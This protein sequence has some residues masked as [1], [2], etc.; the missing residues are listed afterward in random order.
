MYF[1]IVHAGT[2]S[3]DP[4]PDV[5]LGTHRNYTGCLVSGEGSVAVRRESWWGVGGRGKGTDRIAF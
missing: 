2:R 1:V 5:C 3:R 4:T